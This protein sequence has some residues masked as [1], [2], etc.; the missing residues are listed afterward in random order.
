MPIHTIQFALAIAAS[1]TLVLA[2]CCA[3]II[4]RA[5][6][7]GTLL[8]VQSAFDEPESAFDTVD[9]VSAEEP[10]TNP[11]AEASRFRI[12][13]A[14]SEESHALRFELDALAEIGLD[15]AA[16][17]SPNHGPGNGS[18]VNRGTDPTG[19]VNPT[20][21]TLAIGASPAKVP[22]Y[23]PRLT[24]FPSR[25]LVLGII[26]HKGG[27]GKT[28]TAIEL[29][30]NWAA[31]A[32]ALS[33]RRI[34]L[35][36]SD[37][38]QAA[39][40]LLGLNA[41]ETGKI[42]P[43]GQSGL[44]YVHWLPP[45]WPQQVRWP[46]AFCKGWDLVV[47]DTPSLQNPLTV[48]LLPLFDALLLTLT[49]DPAGMRVLE[50]GAI[51]LERRLDPRR[52]RLLG[53]LV[54]RF[55]PERA[56]QASLYSSLQREY[57]GILLPETIPEETRSEPFTTEAGPNPLTAGR[58]AYHELAKRLDIQLRPLKERAGGQT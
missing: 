19:P 1:L 30:R 48:Q 3:W 40:S 38:I 55:Q 20:S 17:R 4:W 33:S 49:L 58:L 25:P 31:Q 34:L 36:D 22:D 6:Q 57:V 54:T 11:T 29:A 15:A 18:G 12:Q 24:E 2:G 46:A 13:A 50:Q 16:A 7:L 45:R 53:V 23:V 5:R 26:S 43:C 37:P 56:L 27:T 42:Y 14:Q 51:M 41:P 52:Q 47:V 35:V 21:P 8:E 32:G 10:H 28:T 44:S 9:A 39:A